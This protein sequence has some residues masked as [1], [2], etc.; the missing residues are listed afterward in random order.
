V[1]GSGAAPATAGQ[2][3]GAPNR[4]NST[5]ASWPS[6]RPG[7]DRQRRR[8]RAD[9]AYTVTSRAA[10]ARRRL[11]D[12]DDHGRRRHHRPPPPPPRPRG[13]GHCDADPA[14]GARARTARRL[15]HARRHGQRRRLRA[16]AGPRSRGPRRRPRP[17]TIAVATTADASTRTTRASALCSHSPTDTV[18]AP[19]VALTI[20]DDDAPPLVGAVRG[21]GSRGR[22][23]NKA[24]QIL[25]ALAQPSGRVVRVPYGKRDGTARAPGDYTPATGTL[26]VQSRRDRQWPGPSASPATRTPEPD[27]TF[28]LALGPARERGA[29]APRRCR[30]DHDH[31]RRRRGRDRR[32]GGDTTPRGWPSGR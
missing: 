7:P 11:G 10:T 1:T 32:R 18:A 9:E 24:L 13:C 15:R 14:R 3:V 2:D 29:R 25:V 12:D 19:A 27:E 23:R 20:A 28:T 22:E 6:H 26:D 16:R 21:Q 30:D 5:S 31:R 4:R 17:K 8:G